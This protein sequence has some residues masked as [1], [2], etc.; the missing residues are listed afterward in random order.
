M[1]ARRRCSRLEW[2]RAPGREGGRRRG[3]TAGVRW[4]RAPATRRGPAGA[5][6]VRRGGR[7]PGAGRGQG[8]E[9]DGVAGVGQGLGVRAR[10]SGLGGGS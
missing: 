2:R 10:E 1:P 6:G 8:P 3:V 4:R 7:R 9:G 5:S